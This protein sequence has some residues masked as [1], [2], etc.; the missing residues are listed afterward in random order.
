VRAAVAV[1]GVALLGSMNIDRFSRIAAGEFLPDDMFLASW[2][3][4]RYPDRKL[5]VAAFPGHAYEKLSYFVS[6][7][8]K[9]PMLS[10]YHNDLLQQLNE[11]EK[12]VYVMIFP[13][14]FEQRFR[15]LDPNG[16]F[17]LYRHDWA[18]FVN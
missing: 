13:E 12:Y 3:N 16:K 18:V 8:R 11:N 6:P 7:R 9:T 15:R 17:R 14:S 5:Y 10:Q 2:V 1:L 4:T